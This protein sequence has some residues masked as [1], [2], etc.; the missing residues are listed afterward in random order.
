MEEARTGTATNRGAVIDNPGLVDVVAD[1][2]Y[3]PLEAFSRPAGWDSDND[4]IPDEWE[5]ANNLNPNLASDGKAKTLDPR[6]WYTNLEVYLNSLVEHIVKGQNTDALTTVDEYFPSS[7]S[8]IGTVTADN[9]SEVVAIEYYST[10]GRRLEAPAA[11]IT[12]RLLRFADGHTETDKVTARS[13]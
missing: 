7:T 5:I 13:M 2:E 1:V 3:V 11:G 10:D 9:A 8:A 12:L 4:G 6:G